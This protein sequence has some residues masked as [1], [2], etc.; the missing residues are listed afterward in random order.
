MSRRFILSA[1]MITLLLTG[2]GA[3][4][5]QAEGSSDTQLILAPDMTGASYWEALMFTSLQGLANRD[6]AK[7]FL[8]FKDIKDEGWYDVPDEEKYHVWYEWY[9][10]YDHLEF[11][12]L[13]DPYELFTELDEMPFDGYVV[14]DTAVPATAN[15]AANYAGSENLLPVTAGMLNS[16]ALPEM[17]IVRDLRGQFNRMSKLEIYQW[18]YENQWP[19]ANHARVAN[20]RTPEP[21]E[22]IDISSFTQASDTIYLKFEDSIKEDG[23]GSRL[24]YVTLFDGGQEVVTVDPFTTE[25]EQYLY[26]KSGTGNSGGDRFANKEDYW[27]YKIDGVQGADTLGMRI[28]NEYMLSASTSPEGP[29]EP[30]SSSTQRVWLNF[31]VI[32]TNTLFTSNRIRDYGVAENTFFFDLYSDGPA[33]EYELKSQIFEE[34]EPRGYV[35]GWGNEAAHITHISQHGQLALGGSTYSD[36]FSFYSRAQIE[37]A[38]ER[39]KE[40]AKKP[41]TVEALEEDKIYL[42]FV[43][44]DGDSLNFITRRAQGGAWLLPERGQIP[45][46]WEIQ[47]ALADIAPGILDYFQATATDNDH[48]TAAVSGVGYFYPEAMPKDKLAGVLEETTDYLKRTG[49]SNLTVMSP[50]NPTGVSKETIEMYADILGDELTGVMEGYTNRGAYREYL[51][52]PKNESGK[53]GARLPV[54]AKDAT[55]WLPTALPVKGK[56][57]VEGMVE[58]L[59]SL[60][61][62]RHQR[63]LFVPIHV[64]AHS[65]MITD[66]VEVVEQLDPDIYKVVGP[67]EFYA[68]F[69]KARPGTFVFDPPEGDLP[70]EQ[71]LVGGVVNLVESKIQGFGKAPMDVTI[72]Y[73]LTSDVF[74]EI[75]TGEQTITLQS[76]NN[77]DMM[78]FPIAV[79]EIDQVQ[80]GQIKYS[81]ADGTPLVT[82]QVTLIPPPAGLPDEVAVSL[83]ISYEAE[84]VNHRDGVRITDADALGGAAWQGIAG[85]H[86]DT[87]GSNHIVWMK[88]QDQNELGDYTAFFRMKVEDN[89]VDQTIATIDAVENIPAGTRGG[90]TAPTGPSLDLKGTDFAESDVYQ[91]IALPFSRPITEHD[92]NLTQMQY[93]VHYEGH[94]TLTVDQIFLVKTESTD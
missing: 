61:E 84:D 27:I 30:I 22:T 64:P 57:S 77:L 11:K 28:R 13:A 85:Q 86:D 82:K 37:G 17:E 29:F 52:G 4:T 8:H 20:L 92:L 19:Q 31:G 15:I 70:A 18:A 74:E 16:G 53:N 48:F 35:L 36:N 54:K 89:T 5:S 46:G 34:M 59:E 81:L 21:A 75:V 79:P 87:T 33:A 68:L 39:F 94:S 38:V 66:M 7:V 51:F 88:S 25:E 72:R 10:Q 55:V 43:L 63:P 41:A 1:L 56:E 69:A 49:L 80:T 26:E 67:D 58:V 24:A 62:V 47:P 9:K 65:M 42:T 73:E 32:E 40:R 83:P 91:W 76:S 60:A 3:P 50:L 78:E 23:F 44:S 6:E 71:T 12:D 2:F 93:R 90:P 14:V 45:F